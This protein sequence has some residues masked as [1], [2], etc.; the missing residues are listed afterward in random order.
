MFHSSVIRSRDGTRIGLGSTS[1]PEGWLDNET[2]IG[3]KGSVKLTC[4]GCPPSF[5]P[6]DM[7]LIRITNPTNI[8]DLGFKGSFIGLV[9]ES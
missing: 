5:E 1:Q 4:S 6:D 2:V 9:R 7:A 3:Q 8:I